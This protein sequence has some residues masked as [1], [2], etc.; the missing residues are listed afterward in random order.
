V[1]AEAERLRTSI[2]WHGYF[3]EAWQRRGIEVWLLKFRLLGA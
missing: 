2:R 3:H 1:D